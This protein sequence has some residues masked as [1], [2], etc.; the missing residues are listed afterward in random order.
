MVP[1]VNMD[2][3]GEVI[4]GP[5]TYTALTQHLAHGG[6]AIIGWTDEEGTHLDILLTLQPFQAGTV[7][8]GYRGA[9]DLFVAI[10]SIGAGAFEVRSRMEPLYPSYVGEKTG[11]GS[12]ENDTTIKLAE[13]INALLEGLTLWSL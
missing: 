8:R 1:N 11:L 6:S 12:V 13:L 10:M 7:Q 3:H 9:T 4:N 5:K 2:E